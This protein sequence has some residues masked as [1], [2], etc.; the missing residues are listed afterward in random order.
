MGARDSRAL[1][2]AGWGH[3]REGWADFLVVCPAIPISASEP[4]CHLELGTSEQPGFSPGLWQPD[5]GQQH[6]QGKSPMLGHA[7]TL[8]KLCVKF[9]AS[10]VSNRGRRR[11]RWSSKVLLKTTK[12]SRWLHTSSMPTL[13]WFIGPWPELD[14]Y[15][16]Q[17][18]AYKTGTAPLEV[19][20]WPAPSRTSCNP[21]AEGPAWICTLPSPGCRW[22]QPCVGENRSLPRW[23]H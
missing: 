3:L 8:V 14:P 16:N 6:D 19:L 10:N 15:S 23:Q 20:A 5:R 7:V 21:L 4:F 22:C 13:R 11:I 17:R 2:V 9:E 12:L 18:E 1:M